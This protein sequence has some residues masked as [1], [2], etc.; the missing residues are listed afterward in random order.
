MSARDG[1]RLVLQVLQASGISHSRVM[2]AGHQ[3]GRIHFREPQDRKPSLAPR[4]TIS[5]PHNPITKHHLTA[6]WPFLP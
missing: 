5:A 3:A 2:S 6:R 1:D 4:T